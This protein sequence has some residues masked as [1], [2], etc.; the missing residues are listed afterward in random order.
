MSATPFA[1]AARSHSSFSRSTSWW[2]SNDWSTATGRP[3]FSIVTGPRWASSNSS[4]KRFFA[5]LADMVRTAV[6]RKGL[7]QSSYF[8]QLQQAFLL[9]QHRPRRLLRRGHDPARHLL[10]LRLDQ[11]PVGGLEPHRD[12]QRLLALRHALALVD[13]EQPDLADQLAIGGPHRVDQAGGRDGRVDQEGEVAGD[14]RGRGRRR[15][16]A[17]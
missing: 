11:R 2:S 17:G 15:R 16:P 14:R 4:P 8:S 12:G 6:P 5:S 9:A 10:D 1:T 3:F 7:S 13:V